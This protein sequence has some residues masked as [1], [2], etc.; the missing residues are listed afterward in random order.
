MKTPADIATENAISFEVK[1]DGLQ[2]RQ[3]GDW[4]L[5]L[6][7]QAKDLQPTDIHQVIVNANMGTRFLCTLVQIDDNEMPVD[8]KAMDRDKWRALGPAKQAGI[9]CKDPVFWAYLSEIENLKYGIANE[10]DAA[11]FVRARCNVLTRSDLGKPGFSDQRILWF[12][13]DNKFQAWK[14]K[15]NA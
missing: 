13:L 9:R 14:A 7:A 4:M 10:E 5:R 8:H 12:D 6:V 1:K 3:N 11:E 2:Q 15:E